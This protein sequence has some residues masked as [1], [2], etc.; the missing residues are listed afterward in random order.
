MKILNSSDFPS[1]L[2]EFKAFGRERPEYAKLF[3]TYQE[4]QAEAEEKILDNHNGPAAAARDNHDE[5]SLEK[6]D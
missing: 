4:M 1:I 5:L 2:G 3:T 6:I